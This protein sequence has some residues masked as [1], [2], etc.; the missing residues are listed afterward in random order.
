MLN[1]G[2]W[3]SRAA[4][5]V[6]QVPLRAQGFRGIEITVSVEPPLG[7][8]EWDALRHAL[9]RGVP[10]AL[11]QFWLTG[12]RH[13]NCRYSCRGVQGD[14]L[15]GGA[16]FIDARELP[17]RLNACR[18]WAEKT[19]VANYPEDKRLWLQSVPF[20]AMENGDY[21]GLFV[22][23]DEEEPPVVYLA[24]DDESFTLAPSF[25]AFLEVWERVAYIGPEVWM[26]DDLL[27]EQSFLD[28]DTER[29]QELRLLLGQT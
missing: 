28:E 7:K 20:I 21:L 5:F 23:S 15:W 19:W 1:Y 11:R 18:E 8:E 27:D 12:S 9:P 26:L 10:T 6:K 4:E 2:E 3:V 13:C 17:D 25:T 14:D 16:R 22:T 29:A 24:H